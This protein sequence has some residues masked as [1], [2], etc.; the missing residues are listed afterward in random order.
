MPVFSLRNVTRQHTAGGT[1]F[2]LVVPRL[3]IPAG[4]KLALVGESGSGKSTLLE[5]LAMILRPTDCDQFTFSPATEEHQDIARIWARNDADALGDL[6]CQHIGY[7][8]Q[9]GGLLPFLSVRDN[10]V[11]SCRLLHRPVEGVAEQWADKLQIGQQLD[12]Y[13]S[14]LSVGQRQRV[15]IA[16]ALAHQPTVLIAD[17][18]TASI[19]P[20]NSERIMN[21]MAGLVDEL[22]VTLI[23][24]SHEHA[25]VRQVGLTMVDHDLEVRDDNNTRVTIANVAA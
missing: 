4:A 20:V 2:Q 25:L 1:G 16:R 11:L 21:L 8:L 15:A 9:N 18:P 14:E 19:D 10:I 13:P 17:E 12:K 6:R 5:L 3:D 24:A 22:G 7:V 23:V